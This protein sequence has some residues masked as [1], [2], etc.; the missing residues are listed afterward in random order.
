MTRDTHKDLL[1]TEL[2]GQ[3]YIYMNLSHTFSDKDLRVNTIKN[4]FLKGTYF[5][6][7]AGLKLF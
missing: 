4:R 3:N 6:E 2:Q 1:Q 7:S 5:L